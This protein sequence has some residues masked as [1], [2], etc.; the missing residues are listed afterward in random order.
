[1]KLREPKVFGTSVRRN[2][3]YVEIND[4]IDSARTLDAV[5]RVRIDF[6]REMRMFKELVA[7]ENFNHGFDYYDQLMRRFAQREFEINQEMEF[8]YVAKE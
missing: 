1:M 2:Q 4:A 7:A 8:E 3:V 5:E 6:A